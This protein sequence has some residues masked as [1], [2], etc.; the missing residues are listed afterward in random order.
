ML[1][2]SDLDRTL[3]YS[4]RFINENMDTCD[5]KSVETL[6][7]KVISYMSLKAINMLL[8]IEKN[9]LFVPVTTRTNTQYKRISF[10]D[11]MKCPYAITTNGGIIL[12]DG[13]IDYEWQSIIYNKL[14]NNAVPLK[15]IYKAFKSRFLSSTWL[16][17]EYFVDEYFFYFIVDE[18]KIPLKKLEE[19]ES[20]LEDN[21]WRMCLNARKLYFIPKCINKKDAVKY[22]ANKEEKDFI[23]TAG[24]S[25]LDLDM[26]EISDCFISPKHGELYQIFHH[27]YLA[28]KIIFTETQG[29]CAS[30]E[31]LE[32]VLRIWLDNNRFVSSYLI[33]K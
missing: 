6:D 28:K 24:D 13:H 8:E 21:G 18:M 16:K 7:N 3:V 10:F 14:K 2:A 22:I 11:K 32:H 12:K 27:Y 9:I 33:I 23:V 1:F 20:W 4:H 31:I 19:F 5:Y 29:L 17:R 15:D 26:L 25:K 30:V